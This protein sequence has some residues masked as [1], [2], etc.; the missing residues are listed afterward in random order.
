MKESR[1]LSFLLLLSLTIAGCGL[2]PG[3]TATPAPTPTPNLPP[4]DEVALAF[5]QAWERGDY[6]VMYSL[7]SPAAQQQ[8][9]ED[10]FTTTYQ[11]V[12]DEAMLLSVTTQIMAA[13]QSGSHADISFATAFASALVGNFDIQNRMP[14]SHVEGRW[15]IDWS[16]SLI[17]PQLS[18]DSFVHM[19]TRVPARGNIYDRN[20]LGLAVEGDLVEIGV[21][22]GQIQDEATLLAQLSAILG[23][24]TAGLQAMYA[25]A[26]ADWYVPL[27]QISAATGQA[28]YDTLTS[29]P[30]VELRSAWTRSYRPEI[31]APHLVGVVGPVPEEEVEV[32]RTRGYTDDDVVGRMGLEMW[33][34]PYLSGERGGQL[35]IISSKGQQIAVLASKPS[36]ESRSLYTTFDREFQKKV[37]DILGERLGAIAVL[38]VKTGRVLA[39]AT[40]P[41]FD[42][43]LFTGGIS[44]QQWQSLQADGRRPL[45]N[46]AT[47][48]TYPP[49]SVFK[50]VTMATAMEKGGLTRSSDFLC[51]GT[52][53]GLGPEWPKTCWLRSGHGHIAL[54]K[55]LTVSCDITFY[56]VALLLNGIDQNLL[57]NY[58]RSFGLGALTGIEVE[59][60]PG[61]VP[62]P[63]W[64]LQ[65]KGEGWAPGDTVNLG[66]GQSE[67]QVTPLQ[68][69]MMLAAVGNGGTL[70]RPQV[71]E[72]IAADPAH[73]EV[74]FQTMVAGQL[75]V[76]AAN[77][78]VIRDSLAKVT[79]AEYGTA[80]AAFKG[81]SL[82]VAGKTGT[83]E[84][85]QNLPHAWFAGYAP[86]DNP[87]IAIA[88]VV[89]NSGEGASYAAPLFRQVVEAYFAALLQPTPAPSATP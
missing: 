22:P 70:Y 48:G 13:Y 8:V 12:T 40:Y 59:E 18:D 61:L 41:N 54:A 32:W 80:Y 55:A 34:E 85:G 23:R 1:I 86:A 45:V 57:P 33:G 3:P 74:T 39:L 68:L 67:I 78:A 72:M 27:G 79:S 56:Q 25:G 44:D 66:I 82:P 49:G 15:G 24:T 29:L 19:T 30:G 43:N 46:R 20:G 83:A 47:Q 76:S 42:P 38:E 16:P 51:Q 63:G 37:Q 11:Q 88:V 84:S 65:T 52:W 5:L 50:I 21:I 64:K 14:L 81:L 31:I 89:E 69:A 10:Q 7:L 9:S 75:P 28:Y 26:P 71:V 58:A 53:T 6:P 87:Q 73:P 36:E 17:F 35:E 60:N 77:L 4:A 2:G 62:D